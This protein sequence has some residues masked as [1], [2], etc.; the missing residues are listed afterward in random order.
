MQQMSYREI[1]ICPATNRYDIL[2]TR[3]QQLFPTWKQSNE[4][5][6]EVA[7]HQKTLA[8]LS[9]SKSWSIGDLIPVIGNSGQ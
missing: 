7:V 1:K 5:E 9:T 4:A 6:F 8:F 3:L 2:K